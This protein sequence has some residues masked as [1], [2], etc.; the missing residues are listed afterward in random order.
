MAAP[1]KPGD[2][3][4]DFEL[5]KL[6]GVGTFA[7]VYAATSPKFPDPVALKISR[8]PVTDEG[9]ALRALREIR[10]LSSLSNAHVVHVYDHGLGQDERW[11]L[12][13]ELLEGQELG[14]RHDFD[15]PLDPEEAIRI[16]YQACLGLDEAHRGGIV[17]RDVKPGNLWMQDD[18]N[19]KVLDFGL[20]RS[21]G[22]DS[23]IGA[24]ATQNHM[25]VGTPHYA[26][27]EQIRQGTLTPASDV[28]SLAFVLY[29]LLCGRTPLF[30]DRPVSAVR[31]E[32]EGQPLLWLA[33]H[34]ER[35]AVDLARYPEGQALD[36]QVRMLLAACLD[37]DPI[38]RPA[39][40]GEL[41]NRLAWALSP[42]HGGYKG[43]RGILLEETS[44]ASSYPRRFLLQ[45]GEHRV[46][47]GSCCDVELADDTVGWVFAVVRWPGGQELP[48]LDPMR[49]DGFVRVNGHPVTG[50]VRIKAGSML[51]FGP[52]TLACAGVSGSI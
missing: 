20:A 17:H 27:P 3:Y 42:E 4:E 49:D 30:E 26:Q 12:V 19:V 31:R 43:A 39:T 1:L 47:L 28:Y 6:L 21:W 48:V 36:P 24:N 29:E 10:I 16:V 2:R 25:L 11:F 22:G 18:G 41:A 13:M 9:T 33:A 32:L 40:A 14:V 5:K 37:K 35:P 38:K 50:P 44:A 7:W 23:I 51:Q 8:Q 15:V 34:A 46:G 52:Y 45:P